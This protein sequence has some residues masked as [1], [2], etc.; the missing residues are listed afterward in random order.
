MARRRVEDLGAEFKPVER[1]WCLRSETFRQELSENTCNCTVHALVGVTVQIIFL[2]SPGR[3]P[4]C[5]ALPDVR[6][7]TFSAS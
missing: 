7:L 3:T 4:F 5:F 2:Q 1:G 6:Q